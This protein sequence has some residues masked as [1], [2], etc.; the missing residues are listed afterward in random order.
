M[1]NWLANDRDSAQ[2]MLPRA[3]TEAGVAAGHEATV[4]EKRK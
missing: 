4:M 2:N 1:N 3:V